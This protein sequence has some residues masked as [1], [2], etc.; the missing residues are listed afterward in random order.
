LRTAYQVGVF[1]PGAPFSMKFEIT[2]A[3]CLSKIRQKGSG[4]VPK[5]TDWLLLLSIQNEVIK[6]VKSGNLPI[7][8]A[9]MG[10]QAII[11][12]LCLT[13]P[14][15]QSNG[16]Y[17]LPQLQL[18]RAK[19]LNIYRKWGFTESDFPTQIPTFNPRTPT[20]V[21]LLAIYLPE[22]GN[23]GAVQRTFYEH[24]AVIKNQM[25]RSGR[26]LLCWDVLKSGRKYL[27]LINGAECRPGIRWV[28]FDYAANWWHNKGSHRV[29]NLWKAP[30]SA[31]LASSEV[32]SA[33]M[34][35]PEW[36]PSMD[37][38]TIPYVNLPGYQCRFYD[39]SGWYYV[40]G[41]V[42]GYDS[43]QLKLIIRD[44]DCH[45]IYWA[46]PSFREC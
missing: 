13:N 27:R 24:I 33:M 30:D 39:N 38:M 22:K 10:N 21:L 16:W 44:A 40:P 43:T 19:R 5:I 15:H 1:Q 28:V 46:S 35:F 37:G 7:E 31:S 2:D 14:D 34:F 25:K 29:I 9:L 12:R 4:C 8:E 3:R 17:V 18:V 42:R 20:E 32:L 11:D 6:L 41:S 45:D 36:G 26:K 23:K